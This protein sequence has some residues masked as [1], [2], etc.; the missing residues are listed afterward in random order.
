M[1]KW[2]PK[3]GSMGDTSPYIV[4]DTNED[5]DETFVPAL[6]KSAQLSDQMIAAC[7]KVGNFHRDKKELAFGYFYFTV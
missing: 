5:K 7:E 3:Q 1:P 6:A 4:K 2:P